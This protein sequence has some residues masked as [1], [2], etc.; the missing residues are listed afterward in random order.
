MAWHM[1]ICVSHTQTDADNLS[2]TVVTLFRS[3]NEYL[4]KEV[5]SVDYWISVNHA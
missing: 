1:Y 5:T 3:F 4:L 2:L